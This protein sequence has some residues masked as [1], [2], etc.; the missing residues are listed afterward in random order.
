MPLI[1][2]VQW[3][4]AKDDELAK[5]FPEVSIRYG[6]QLTVMENQWGVFFR[7]GRA[8]D[9]FES[10]RHTLTSKNIPIL[11]DLVQG[12]GIIGDIFDCCHRLRDG[13][14]EVHHHKDEETQSERY[15]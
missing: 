15:P 14:S 10:G 13:E 4:E 1:E 6:S 2:A 9:V 3:R 8:L 5:R 11:I 12:L 7:D